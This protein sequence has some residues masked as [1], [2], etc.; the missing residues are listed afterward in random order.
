MQTVIRTFASVLASAICAVYLI[1]CGRNTSKSH[2]KLGISSLLPGSWHVDWQCVSCHFW[3][4]SLPS[5][6]NWAVPSF[7]MLCTV[8]FNLGLKQCSIITTCPVSYVRYTQLLYLDSPFAMFPQQSDGRSAMTEALTSHLAYVPNI[9]SLSAASPALPLS[10]SSFLSLS[11]KLKLGLVF[12][13]SLYEPW[14]SRVFVSSAT[15]QGGNFKCN[16]LQVY[17][18][19]ICA[20]SFYKTGF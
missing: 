14:S 9:P 19:I 2:G 13:T 5:W 16:Y 15:Q 12:V 6:F 10:R 18:S 20:C 8:K 17:Y 7:W 3:S 4:G 1:L 11:F